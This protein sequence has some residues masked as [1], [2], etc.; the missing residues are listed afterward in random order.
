MLSL[1]ILIFSGV[2]LGWLLRKH[3]LHWLGRAVTLLVWLL[4]LLLGVEA[5]GNPR[6]MGSLSTL[7]VEAAVIA[8]SGL[9]GSCLC[10]MLLWK[11]IEG[12]H[13]GM[14]P[15]TSCGNGTWSALKGS[16]VTVSF[17]AAGCAAG[18]SG[19]LPAAFTESEISYYALCALIL[20]V[21]MGVG[22]DRKTLQSF[23][24][25]DARFALLPVGT[26]LGTLAAVA[27]AGLLL[28]HRSLT[29]ALATGS[30]FAYYSLSSILITE[31][32]GAELGTMALLANVIREVATLLGAPLIVRWFGRLAPISCGGAASMDST[33]SVI[34][35]VC[36]KEMVPVS[37]FHG[38]V[39]DTSVPF[40]VTF[41]CSL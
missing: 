10:A 22:N 18:A 21:G 34:T 20:C 6:V 35:Q 8:F 25:L 40:W 7:G 30:G 37:V 16:V 5:G 14:N 1:I 19:I 38:F 13:K 33:L 3:E 27:L 41:F 11:I 32:R 39:V 24:R 12:R 28:P 17:F 31:Y 29:D 9:L 4:L 15:P 36:G 23:R 2:L 26:M